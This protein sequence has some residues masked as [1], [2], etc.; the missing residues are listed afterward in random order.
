MTEIR[1][2]VSANDLPGA[3]WRKSSY[4]GAVGNCVELSWFGERASV[5]NSRDPHGPVL[6]LPAGSLVSCVNNTV[7]IGDRRA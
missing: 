1:N 5:R 3:T 6:V 7:S 4:S 2:G